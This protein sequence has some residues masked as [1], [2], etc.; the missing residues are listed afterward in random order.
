M[1]T[2]YTIGYQGRSLADLIHRLQQVGV[3]AVIDVRLRNTSHLAGYTKK[4]DLAFLLQEGFGIAYEHHPELAPTDE[5][6]DMYRADHDWAGYE[7][8]F[9]ALLAKRK[10]E[11]VG[12]EIL[13]RYQAPCLLCLEADPDK[14]HRHLVVARWAAHMPGLRIVHL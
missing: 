12:R 8:R 11:T 7:V 6:L 4:A 13:S 5:I 14:C 9:K 1:T 10:V 2:L 3:D